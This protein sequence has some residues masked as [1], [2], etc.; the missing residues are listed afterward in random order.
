MPEISIVLPTFNGEKYIRQAIDSILKQT[1][2]NW[3]LIIVD[4]CS[5]DDTLQVIN[6]YQKMDSRI[7]VIHNS[8]NQKLP[9]SLNIGFRYSSG[10]FLT[11][12]SDDNYYLPQAL[13]IMHQ[14]LYKNKEI[15]MVCA[16]M[17]MI[18]ETNR[19]IDAMPS[20]NEI[21]M[22]YYNCVGACFLYR[23]EVW[24]RLGDYDTELFLVEDY[25]YWLRII[26]QYNGIG[27]I[28]QTLYEYRTHNNSLTIKK[29]REVN[30]KIVC[31][32]RK[33]FSL[34][35]NKIK[36]DKSYLCKIF[37][38][39][40]EMKKDIEDIKKEAFSVIPE[41]KIDVVSEAENEKIIIWGAGNYGEK[42]F[43]LLKRKVIYFVDSNVNKVGKYKCGLE[44]IS[45][46]ELLKLYD[47]YNIVIAVSSEKIYDILHFLFVN[48]IKKCCT[49][50]RRNLYNQIRNK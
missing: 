29:Q 41:L 27:Y 1:F 32:R 5:T 7:K 6:G 12:T 38:D 25:D 49:Y 11:W 22:F 19:V 44:I 48:G 34:L 37:Y 46:E 23:R 16:G 17:N 2:Q 13:E 40:L 20:Y 42:A 50:Q 35:L 30:E 24:E 43:K 45:K 15:Y 21:Q 3:E 4:D 26:K 36:D 33:H 10:R 9:C 18:D 14:Y 31:L 28:N 47:K 8:E 39:C